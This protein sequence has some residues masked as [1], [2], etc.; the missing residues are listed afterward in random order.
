MRILKTKEDTLTEFAAVDRID[1]K[2]Y[3]NNIHFLTGE[4]EDFNIEQTIRWIISENLDKDNS[5]PLELWVNSIGGD[6]YQGFALIDVMKSSRRPIKTVGVGSIQSC[7]FLI[8]VSGTKGLRTIHK[9]TG[10]MCHQYS[11]GSSGK[12]HDL[13]ASMREGVLCDQRMLNILKDATGLSTAKVKSK[14][15]TTTDVYLSAEELVALNGAD[16]IA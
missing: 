16:I 9:N 6:L 5:E 8:F 1:I 3:E 2:L 11:G 13:K 7:G 14:L 12:H 10:I 4:I 15:L